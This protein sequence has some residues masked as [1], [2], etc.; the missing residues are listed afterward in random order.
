MFLNFFIFFGY[1]PKSGISGS[2]G[3]STFSF[4]RNLHTVFHNGCSDLHSHQQC[5]RV[6]F[7]P[8]PLQ[9]FL[10]V[11]FLMTAILT[12]VRW[13]LIMVLICISLMI[14]DV[15][16]LFPCLLAIWMSSLDKCL[17]TSSADFLI[18]LFVFLL[19]SYMSCLYILDINPLSNILFANIFSHSMGCIFI[20]SMVF[21]AVQKLVSL[22]RSRLFIFA[23][24]SFALGDWSK[25]ILL[26]FMSKNVLLM[27]SSGS[28][29]VSFTFRS[30]I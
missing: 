17:F 26:Q 28:F 9:H 29:M 27:F 2:Y 8:H 5:T 14:N 12:G 10:F 4:L 7:A 21:F 15:E 18:W 3:S 30:S 13:Y 11:F 24:I 22:M 23:F 1:I 6:P 20:L 25:K 19:S 16:H